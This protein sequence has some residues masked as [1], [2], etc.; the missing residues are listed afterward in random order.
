MLAHIR[1][2]ISSALRT[3]ENCAVTV[4]V[5]TSVIIMN[6]LKFDILFG[7]DACSLCLSQRLFFLLAGLTS[8]IALIH[9][10]NLIAYPIVAG[11]WL[12][13]GLAVAIQHNWLLWGPGD[14]S[15]CG[16]DVLY[17]IDFGYPV[18]DVFK[19]LLVGSVSC[20]EDSHKPF[21]AAAIVCYLALLYVV[22]TQVRNSLKSD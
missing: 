20:G 18:V 19:T 7:F 3:P 12:G 8:G 2:L 15:T 4:L 10:S 9:R 13:G 1:T 14:A 5:A 21:A 16:P 22:V 17:L 11:L 6:A